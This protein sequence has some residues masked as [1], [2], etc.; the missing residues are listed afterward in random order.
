[1]G[2]NKKLELKMMRTRK[3]RSFVVFSRNKY[4]NIKYGFFR[5]NNKDEHYESRFF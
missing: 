3:H 2:Y 5:L 1:V 4:E